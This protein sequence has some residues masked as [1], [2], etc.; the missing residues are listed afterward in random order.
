MSTETW[1][2][3]LAAGSGERFGGPKHLVEIGGV[4]MWRRSVEVFEQH[5]GID[6][7]VVVGDVPGGVPG[8]ERRQDSVRAGLAALPSGCATVLVHDGARPLVTGEIIDRVLRRLAVGDCEGVIPVLP[9]TDTVKKVE[10]D[11]VTAT[12]DRATMVTVQ[13][14]QGFTRSVLADAHASSDTDVT[15]DAAMVEAAGGT[16]AVVEGDA[17]NIKITYPDDL[18]TAALLL[19]GRQGATD[20]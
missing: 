17:S 19:A 14:P 11:R 15:D 16:V 1:A 18:P 9:M 10:G 7:V 13:T 20:G 4:P 3:V 6:G 2:I 8:G 5:H 12:L